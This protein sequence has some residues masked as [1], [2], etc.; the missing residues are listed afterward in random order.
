VIRGDAEKKQ[1]IIEWLCLPKRDRNPATQEELAKR[2]RISS[3]TITKWKSDP[4][5][6]EKWDQH[7]LTTIGSPERKQALLDTLYRTGTDADDPRHVQA[8]AKYME[9]VE[10]L[11]PQKLDITV[12]RPAKDLSDEELDQIAAQYVARER[13]AREQEQAS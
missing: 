5:F 8:A 1:I 12:H 10:G 4:R 9:L 6:V 11:K 2:L 3:T 13:A 7:Y